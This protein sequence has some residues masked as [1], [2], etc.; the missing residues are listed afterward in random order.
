MANLFPYSEAQYL[1]LEEL[2]KTLKVKFPNLNDPKR[3]I[4][5]EEISG[6]RGKI[7]PGWMFDWNRFYQSAYPGLNA[8]SHP[9]RLNAKLKELA[10]HF[11]SEVVV[12]NPRFKESGGEWFEQFNGLLEVAQGN[13]SKP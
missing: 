11:V 10:L 5:H 3:V 12:Q 6:Y 2:F 4:A 8:P 13:G 7:D 9:C 1:A